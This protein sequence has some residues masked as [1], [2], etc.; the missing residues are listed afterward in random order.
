MTTLH[1]FLLL[2]TVMRNSLKGWGGVGKLEDWLDL[3]K[4]TLASVVQSLHIWKFQS[5]TDF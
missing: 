1:N 2:K 3:R 4:P 5:L